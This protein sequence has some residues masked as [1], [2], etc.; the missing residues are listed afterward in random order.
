MYGLAIYDTWLVLQSW[1][2][3]NSIITQSLPRNAR[4]DLRRHRKVSRVSQVCSLIQ[5]SITAETQRLSTS[6]IFS[7]AVATNLLHED[8]EQIVPL[9]LS[10]AS[11]EKRRVE[12]P[13]AG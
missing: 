2:T 9:F 1:T 12:S 10:R 13:N 6:D 4:L 8:V 11:Y 5:L 7:R 3:Y